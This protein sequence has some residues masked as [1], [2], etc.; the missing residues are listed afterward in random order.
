VEPFD[1]K[2]VF[3]APRGGAFLRVAVWGWRA[4]RAPVV[5]SG[6]NE[7]P[8]LCRLPLALALHLGAMPALLAGLAAPTPVLAESQAALFSPQFDGDP[9]RPPRF[10]RAA[11]STSDGRTPA[12]FRLPSG[13][14]S[15]GFDSGRRRAGKARDQRKAAE[16][17]LPARLGSPA[18]A[19]AAP[20]GRLARGAVR[21][22]TRIMPRGA[23]TPARRRLPVDETPFEPLG[24]AFGAFVFKPAIEVTGGY[25][26]NPARSANRTSSLYSVVTPE[27]KF[28]S[29][30][31][32]H[33][34]AGDLRGSY[35]SYRDLPS[36]NRPNADAKLTGRIDVI[37]DTRLDLETRFQVGTDN[38]GSPNLQAGLA[39]L[40]IFTT[41]GGTIGLG[42]R[43]NRFD[44]AL[45]GGA[46]R[47]LYQ[48]S[49]FTDGSSASNDDRNFNRYLTQLRGSYELT[50]GVK[51][52][53]EVGGDRRVHDLAV[54]VFGLRRDSEGRFIKAGSTFELTRILTG[55]VAV[56][57]LSRHY[58]DPSLRDLT[59]ATFDASL[60]W[61]ASALTTAKLTATTRADESRV[62]GV[63]G[64]FAHDIA[65]QVDHAF[66]R[67][68]VGTGKLVYGTDDY[69]GST[70]ADKRY[71]ASLALT[72]KLTRELWLKAEYR[73]DWLRSSVP[74]AGYDADVVLVGLRVQR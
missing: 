4:G 70:R 20:N 66:R 22:S 53:V 48:D 43:F 37:G 11:S 71:S 26:S 33:Q 40:P 68:L 32:R 60:T 55:D 27:L 16:K 34:F 7:V 21:S 59:G 57:W 42:H 12:E 49:T 19:A 2:R 62:F 29:N 17:T 18:A 58:A 6:G 52:F 65:L 72:N 44:V 3:E 47:T 41:W 74:G 25:D 23:A 10:Q 1:P 69:V 39:K 31:S 64:V 28:S 14:G 30:W 35:F 13:A 50:P 24:V 38:P 61:V 5:G 56:G 9:R 36:Q 45:K 51:P 67:W 8:R 15:T 73:H 46:E 54:D 63:S